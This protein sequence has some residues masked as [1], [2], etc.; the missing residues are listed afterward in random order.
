MARRQVKT[1]GAALSKTTRPIEAQAQDGA[2]SD[3]VS[4]LQQT[5]LKNEKVG[6]GTARDQRMF[7]NYA[8]ASFL[9]RIELENIYMTSWLGNRIISTL[10][11]DMV[12]KWRRVS[13][14]DLGTDEEKSAKTMKAFQRYE[15]KMK[16][17][18]QL[19]TASK[20]ARLYGGA[21][22]IPVLK[23]QP[24]EVLAEPLDYSQIEKDD[25][26][27]IHVF[28]R[29]RA[30]HD[31]TL[32]NDALDPNAGMPEHYRL[33]E[34][35]VR[36]HH[37]RVIRLNGRQLPYFPFRANSMWDDSVLRILINNLKQY[38]TA[39]AALTT[40]MFQLNVDVV[41]QSGLRALL[42]TKGGAVK[43]IERFREFAIT[44]A[45]N[46]IAL[47]DKDTEEF[48]RHPYTFSGVDKAFDKVMYDV[49][50]AADVPFTRLFGQSPAGMNATG[51]SDTDHYYDHVVARREEHLD[52]PLVQLDEF[53]IRSFL[54]DMPDDYESEWLPLE[55]ES[56]AE[57]AIT[58]KTKAETA[59][60]HW[61]MGAIDE[62]VV[63]HDIHSRSTYKGMTE[64]HV[65]AAKTVARTRA[66]TDQ[67]DASRIS[68][69]GA[70]PSKGEKVKRNQAPTGTGDDEDSDEEGK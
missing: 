13:W 60:I 63:A 58:E 45:F 11:E 21:L 24:D 46:G 38:D 53:V 32:I 43:A 14:G 33:A 62:G 41:L 10:P 6:I 36:L 70:S 61:N 23:S 17:K 19:L 1:L 54:G 25:L 15:K 5:S 48:Q 22:L 66:L 2:L 68:D 44:K 56:D 26:V 34:S 12:K 8:P 40:M 47:L 37:T 64:Q 3:F 29:W 20:W 69:E 7:T 42:G 52:D 39:V 4:G 27:A 18:R 57:N 30:A 51:E 35:T 31:G 49:C 16:V 67:A 28:D 50:G 9:N 55:Q 65:K 59:Q